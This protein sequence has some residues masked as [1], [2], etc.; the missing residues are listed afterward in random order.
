MHGLEGIKVLE[1]GNMVSAA[2][3]TKLLADLGAE[4]IKVEELDGDHARLRGPFPQGSV[5]P[6]HSGLFLSLNTNKRGCTLDLTH[7]PQALQQLV[8]WAD[9]LVHNYSPH[10]MEARGISYESF[11]AINPRLVMCSITPFGLSGPHKDYH[12][13]EL[14]LAHGGG[15]AW[16]SPGGSERADLPPLKAFGQQ[17][18]FQAGLLAATTTLAAYFRTHATGIGEHIDLSAQSAVASF[19]E[20]NVYFYSYTGRIASRLGRKILA[21]LGIYECQ[22][23]AILLLTAQPDQLQ[24]LIAFM[25]NPEW[26]QA[27]YCKSP[28]T[29]ARHLD[30]VDPHIQAWVKQW[31]VADLFHA[32]QAQRIC[33]APVC[34]MADLTTQEQLQERKFFVNVTH[35]QAGTLTHLG[36]PYQLA[37]PWWALR[38]P[39]PLL[40]E[41]NAEVAALTASIQP[42]Q[43][44]IPTAEQR[45]S[46][47]PLA[48]V[49]VLALTWAWAGPYCAL[50]LA[51]LGA[52]VIHIESHARPDGSRQVPIQPKGVTPSLNTSG[53]FNQWNQGT[54][55]ITLN[56]SKPEAKAIA[57]RLAAQCDVVV[58]NFATGVMERLGLG[59]DDLK[60]VKPD[61]ILA[62]ISGYGQTGPQRNYMGY[63]PAMGPLSGLS[64]LT[65][66]IGGSPQEVGMAY[67]DPNGGINAAIAVCAALV[68]RQRTG[69]G[70]HIDVSLWESMAVLM[71]EGWMDYQMNGQQPPRMGNRD[72]WMAPHNCFRCAGQDEWV[73]LACGAD[74][75]WQA[76][77]RL[78]GQPHLGEDERFRTATA[79]KLHE[80]ELEQI[81]NAWTMTQDKWEVTHQL[82]AV[83]IAAYPTLSSKD[84]LADPHLNARG[85]FVRLPHA[86][87]GTQS[88]A[89]MPW[90]LT[91][92]PNG[93][94][95][96]APLLGQHT[97]AVLSELLGYSAAEIAQLKSERILY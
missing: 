14:T 5:D 43:A 23:G 46:R 17:C 12:A 57:K 95:A 9:I 73:A 89:G 96:P 51:H 4:V 35:P 1:L 39:A 20:M 90:L 56:F 50:Q 70:Q 18:G 82:Q 34:T 52:E 38:R 62:S 44:A 3:A 30:V 71:A 78:I 47:L 21:P 79:R 7:E 54:K 41:H 32:A 49:R 60:Q 45:T 10:E 27:D 87:V 67:G 85:F 33:V 13:H 16:L 11:R 81:V 26:A 66:Y 6:E 55:S 93:V 29:L 80:D 92:T 83:G 58:Q 91:N 61:I 40:G 65:G 63:G 22:D 42:T 97:E 64:S 48:G 59:Y 2:Y 25:G 94:R 68:A 31:K 19:V 86:E 88:H 75:E 8:A 28:F 69:R 24:R 72:Q 76:L 74:A 84:L 15:W 77:S 53:Y 36:A 37:E